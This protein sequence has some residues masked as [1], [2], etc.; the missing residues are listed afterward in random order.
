MIKRKKIIISCGGTG[1]HIFPGLEIA[2]ALQR[3]NS[4]IDIIFVG[5]SGRME[6]E[7]VPKSG[8]RIIGI[9]IQ[10]IYR[11]SII[12]N[13]LFPIKLI[14]SLIQ[15]LIILLY[16]R[17]SAVIGTGGFA[18]FPV[19]YVSS[20]LRIKTYIQEQNCYAG[21]ANK[22]LSKRAQRIFVAHD[23][24]HK[25]FP[26]KKILNFGN[27]VRKSLKIDKVSKT[28][29]RKYFEL[30]EDV[31]TILIIGG[32]LGAGPINRTLEQYISNSSSFDSLSGEVNNLKKDFKDWEQYAPGMRT[33]GFQLIWQTGFQDYNR[34]CDSIGHSK[35]D[36]SVKKQGMHSKVHF[37]IN[38]AVYP[39]IERMDLAYKSADII[40]SRAGAIAIAEI[41]FL[42]K[43]C[44]LIPSPYVTDN[45][46]KKNAEYL[47][48]NNASFMIDTTSTN[49]NGQIELKDLL[50]KIYS[51]FKNSKLINE[52]G[53]NANN[54]FKYNAAE[55]IASIVIKDIQN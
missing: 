50:T 52:M 41:C 3:N 49:Y 12:R 42:S 19:L 23:N 24:M 27:P 14:V 40:V 45:H 28:Q 10:G 46:Q 54:L 25:F 44:I 43:A 38:V 6:M 2:K 35:T 51:F 47:V 29:S 18:S 48:K 11:K 22:L 13:I 5:A 32:S 37:N 26:E 17:P 39:F 16:Y 8:F 55:D 4:N 36:F 15:S 34:V 21:L 53:E 1:G 7:Q 33:N 30:K 9:W 20:F 31:F